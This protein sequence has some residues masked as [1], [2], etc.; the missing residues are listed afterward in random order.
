MRLHSHLSSITILSRPCS[1]CIWWEWVN[2][3][4]FLFSWFSYFL[5]FLEQY[6]FTPTPRVNITILCWFITCWLTWFS[7]HYLPS[8]GNWKTYFDLFSFQWFLKMNLRPM[9]CSGKLTNRSFFYYYYYSFYFFAKIN[10]T[11]R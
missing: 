9:L 6:L 4:C 8:T 7:K 11:R 2:N 1:R 3:Y 10:H 5:H